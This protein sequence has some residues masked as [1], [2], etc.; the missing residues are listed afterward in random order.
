[1][2]ILMA[3]LQNTPATFGHDDPAY[4]DVHALALRLAQRYLDSTFCTWRAT[5][6]STSE[7]PQL[8]GFGPE[9]V[10]IMFEKYADNA[11]NIA[12]G[13]GEYEVVEGFGWTNGVLL[14]AV[15]EFKN[16]LTRPDCGDL[17]AA[18][19]ESRSRHTRRSALEL[20][21]SDAQ[22]VKRFGRKNRSTNRK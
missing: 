13:G 21:P 19:V 8:P 18:D 11:T 17:E 7:T 10:G 14:W 6:G 20:S 5:G 12:G 9:D 4:R 15:D 16:E 3:G 1:M 2:H 22:R